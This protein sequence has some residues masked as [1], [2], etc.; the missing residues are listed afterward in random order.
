M[1]METEVSPIN[2]GT[3]VPQVGS[4]SHTPFA[5]QMESR[6]LR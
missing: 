3:Q 4:N 6:P 2:A 1:P 5:R